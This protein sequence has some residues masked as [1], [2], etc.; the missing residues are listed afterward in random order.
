MMQRVALVAVAA[1]TLVGVLG[2]GGAK[3]T[4]VTQ[5]SSVSIN[6]MC[7][8][9]CGVSFHSKRHHYTAKQVRE[10]FAAQGIRFGKGTGGLRKI[11]GGMP[12][13]PGFAVLVH[14]HK[15]HVITAWVRTSDKPSSTLLILG[16]R[17]GSHYKARKD[18]NV[19]VFFDPSNTRPVTAALARLH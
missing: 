12:M 9:G 16:V 6:V 7:E 11:Y 17:K 14:G 1:V 10:A 5:G 3:R 8:S 18:G 15:P 4:H 2:C 19:S 13:P